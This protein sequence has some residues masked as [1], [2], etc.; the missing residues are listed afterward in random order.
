MSLIHFSNINKWQYKPSKILLKMLYTTSQEVYGSQDSPNYI[1]Y[2][3]NKKTTIS[4]IIPDIV[5]IY[6]TAV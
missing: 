5:N 6:S 1:N 2:Q 3:I 4:N